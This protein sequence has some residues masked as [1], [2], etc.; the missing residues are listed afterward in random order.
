M[1]IIGLTVVGIALFASCG[2]ADEY[3]RYQLCSHK[4][5]LFKIDS[6]SGATSVLN[7]NE[8]AFYPVS[9]SSFDQVAT[10]KFGEAYEASVASVVREN[11][12]R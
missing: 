7:P 1:K 12:G 3:N 8:A 10:N 5:L 4:N 6:Y 11:A 9:D 2:W